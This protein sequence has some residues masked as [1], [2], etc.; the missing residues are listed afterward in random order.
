LTIT[1][2]ISTTSRAAAAWCYAIATWSGFFVMLVELLGG[3]LISP[4]FGSSIY[5]WGSVIFVFMLG[6]ALGYLAGGIYSKHGGT[7][8]KLAGLLILAAL[9]ALPMVYLADPLLNWL[10]D[11]VQDPRTG[12]LL[13]CLG[14]YL[15]P[16]FFS[17]MVSPVAVKIL[18]GGGGAHSGQKAGFLYFASTVGSSAGTLMTSFYLVLWAE[19]NTILLGGIAIS[20]TLGVLA[21]L[22][23]LKRPKAV[24]A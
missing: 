24:A 2:S 9:S 7:V 22:L 14:L 16:S 19:V 4:F 5:V 23:N 1:P 8:P 10:F 17:G 13:S 6:L 12:S 21:I 18:V 11:H 15:V 3:R 20:C